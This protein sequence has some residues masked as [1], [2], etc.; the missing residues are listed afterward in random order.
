MTRKSKIF[1]FVFLLLF[2]LT[3]SIN[4]SPSFD[5][6]KEYIV[7]YETGLIYYQNSI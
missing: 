4:N 6:N 1:K 3:I 5:I 2:I 7:I